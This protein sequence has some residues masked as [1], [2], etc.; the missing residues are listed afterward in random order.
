VAFIGMVLEWPLDW[1]RQFKLEEQFGFNRM[2]PG[3]F[4]SDQVK[5]ILLGAVIGIPLLAAIL[6][7]MQNLPY[8]WFWAWVLW[9]SFSLVLSIIGPMLILPMFNKL[10]PLSDGSL[11]VRV[12]GLMKRCQFE[13]Q[14]LFVMDGSKRSSHGNAF[15]AGMG[16]GRR[17]VLFDTILNQL[18]EQ[19]IEAVLAHELGHF[20]RKH[21]V[22]RLVPSLLMVLPAFWLIDFLMQQPWFFQ[23]LGVTVDLKNNNHQGV[24]LV[25]FMI[26][27]P[28][29]TFF[30]SPLG[31]LFSRKHEF[32]ADAFAAEHSS[33][34]DLISAL[35]K[36]YKDNA[37]TL[38]P[39]P[40]HS[41]F[42]DSHPPAAIRIA[43]LEL[44]RRPV[45]QPTVT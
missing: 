12:L 43:E 31:G 23:G 6:W 39:D 32:E 21:I 19:E 37:S 11:K 33:A 5:G 30:V 35:V 36:M 13:A 8:W 34:D 2:T 9:V 20:K 24:A 28:V 41:A 15:F 10:E 40:L 16:K 18:N 25:L 26:A 3:L 4:I 7:I 44:L 27:L 1:Y 45:V 17:I 22:K 38:T 29:F 42:Y 14:G